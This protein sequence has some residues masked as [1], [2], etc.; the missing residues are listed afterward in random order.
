[1][2][3]ILRGDVAASLASPLS[4]MQSPRPPQ[5]VV[6]D[7]NARLSAKVGEL[8]SKLEQLERKRM[9]DVQK[10]KSEGEAAGRLEADR[11]AKA[12]AAGLAKAREDFKARLADLDLLAAALVRSAL[13]KVFHDSAERAED[14]LSALRKWVAD[15]T[16]AAQFQI[17][18]SQS[19]LDEIGPQRLAEALGNQA[20]QVCVSKALAPGECLIETR[21]GKVD[22]APLTQWRELEKA[23]QIMLAERMP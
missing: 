21:I 13:A 4:Q 17:S 1:M 12:L 11:L 8:E 15:E 10:A 3:R 22:L 18:M 5:P 2:S 20:A 14:V 23:F 16:D 19:D 6:D 9:T 7:E